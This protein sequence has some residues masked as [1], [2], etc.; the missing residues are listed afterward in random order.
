MDITKDDRFSPTNAAIASWENPHYKDLSKPMLHQHNR[1]HLESL[2][3]TELKAIYSQ[4]GSTVEVTD[5]RSKASWITAILD[6]QSA[7]VEKVA[8]A[9][10]KVDEQPKTC[11]DCPLFKPFNDGTGRG[12]CCASDQVARDHHKLTQDCLHL[13]DEQAVAQAELGEYIEAQAEAIAPEKELSRLKREQASKSIKV[14]EKH[15]DTYIV[16]NEENGNHYAVHPS[17]EDPNERCECADCHFRGV[18]CKHQI[19]VT[20]YILSQIK[21]TTPEIEIDSEHDED[22]G[23]L[24]RVWNERDLIGTYYQAID[25]G[26]WIAQ[27][28]CSDERPRCDTAD[29]AQLLVVAISGLLVAGEPDDDE[30]DLLDKPFDELTVEDWQKLKQRELLVA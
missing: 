18:R 3:L 24:Y 6:H 27:P 17:H 8:I 26:K 13:I 29:E 7:Q 14:L 25:D 11:A 5:K 15:G 12:L 4:T 1:E 10:V 19:A 2:S 23:V 28:S 22:F 21:V 9:E 16:C 30:E 20:S